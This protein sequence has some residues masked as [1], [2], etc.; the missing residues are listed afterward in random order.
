MCKFLL[1]LHMC[2]MDLY[3]LGKPK[4]RLSHKQLMWWGIH[5]GTRRNLMDTELSMLMKRSSKTQ[6][7]RYHIHFTN[8]M[9]H[10]FQ[11]IIHT[12]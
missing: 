10:N 9:S 11:R 5:L 1:F 12:F 4:C 6:L 7:Y 8:D 2:N 3:I